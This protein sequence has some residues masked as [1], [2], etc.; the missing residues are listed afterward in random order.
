MKQYIADLFEYDVH[1]NQIVF[2]HELGDW[3]DKSLGLDVDYYNFEIRV[4]SW[5][6]IYVNFE[7]HNVAPFNHYFN[8][9]ERCTGFAFSQGKTQFDVQIRV[10]EEE[11]SPNIKCSHCGAPWPD[12]PVMIPDLPP[13]HIKTYRARENTIDIYHCHECN[14]Y[15]VR[16]YR[17]EWYHDG[18]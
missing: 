5:N 11:D 9:D 8:P 10:K 2:K 6:Y 7:D 1:P 15:F 17:K 4:E 18:C 13:Q 14:K 16:E 12:E 3:L